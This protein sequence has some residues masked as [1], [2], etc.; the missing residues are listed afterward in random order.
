[1]AQNR[2]VRMTKK[3]I[4]DAYLELMERSASEKISVTDICKAADVNRSTFYAHYEDIPSLRAEL[5]RDVM[6]RI[7]TM[8]DNLITSQT[9]FLDMLEHFFSYIQENARLFRTLVCSDDKLFAIR[10]IETVLEQYH[11]KP[12]AKSPLWTK[13]GY[14]YC[15]N[16]VI[17]ILKSW[18]EE[19]FPVSAKE[20]AQIAY[21]MSVLTGKAMEIPMQ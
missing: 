19:N 21:H 2:R 1:M 10:L 12:N 11:L 4:Q 13:Y 15:L 14:L 8:T 20:F 6:E 5:E 17:G 9:Q 7:P 16:G 3:V 18:I